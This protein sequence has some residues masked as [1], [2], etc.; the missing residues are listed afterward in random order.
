M[1]NLYVILTIILGIILLFMIRY[2]YDRHII[3]SSIAFSLNAITLIIGN[4]AIY[5]L[6]KENDLSKYN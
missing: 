5:T 2:L 3:T 4:I 1:K 6:S